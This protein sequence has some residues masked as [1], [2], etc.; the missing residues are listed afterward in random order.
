MKYFLNGQLIDAGQARISADDGGFQ[1]A[2]GLFET[3]SV[4]GGRTFRMEEHLHRLAT[5]AKELGLARE[6]NTAPL[7]EAVCQT[8]AANAATEARL[9][10]T[11]TAGSLSMLRG[12]GEQPVVTPTILIT[13]SEPTTYDPAYFDEGITVLIAPP[14]ANPMDPTAGHKT[15]NY[16]P[17][18]RTL[19]QAA[20]V[21]AGEAIW[22]NVS[23][24][25]AGGAISNIFLAKDDE[26]LTPYARGEEVAG[27]LPAPVLPGIT[28]QAVIEIAESQGVTVTRRMLNIEDLLGADEVFLTNSSWQI[29]P[30]IKVEKHPIGDGRVGQLTQNL[31][32]AL[33]ASL[34]TD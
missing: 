34:T 26:L 11:I 4:Y 12:E 21:G 18:L 25:L 24:H 16:W 15:L 1:H 3:M 31:R 30:V 10:L 22:L 33:L 9:R 6:L 17:R 27:A 7:A 19:R 8:I 2:V 32:N 5:S 28:R 29:L 23:N 13:M 14:M 20:S